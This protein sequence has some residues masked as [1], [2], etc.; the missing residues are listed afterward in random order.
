MA[1]CASC[2]IC[3]SSRSRALEAWFLVVGIASPTTTAPIAAV[4]TGSTHR[5]KILSDDAPANISFKSNLTLIK[6]SLH[7]KAVF[8]RA[9]ARFNACSPALATAKPALFLSR[10]PARPELKRPQ[11][12]RTTCS[13]PKRAAAFSLALFQKPR[14]AAANRGARPN[15][16][17]MCFQRRHPLLLIAEVAQGHS[18]VADKPLF[19]FVDTDQAPKFIGLVSFALANDHTVRFKEAQDF[20]RMPCLCLQNSRPTLGNDLLNQGQVV[21]ERSFCCKDFQESFRLGH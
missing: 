18:I 12:G 8:E 16:L 13:T 10:S 14:S 21:F 5:H 11:P 4:Q 19:D 15:Q 20:V 2:L 17:Q 9:Q 6:G 7:A 3:L 1:P